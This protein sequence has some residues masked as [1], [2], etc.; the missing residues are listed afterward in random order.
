MKFESKEIINGKMVITTSK[1]FLF[2]HVITHYEAQRE[3][4]TGYWDWLRLPSRALV[5]NQKSFQLD[6]WNRI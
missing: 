5:D 1:R 2:W 4:P 3:R 6:A